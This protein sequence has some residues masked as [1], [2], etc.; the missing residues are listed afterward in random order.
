MFTY[1]KRQGLTPTD[2]RGL[3]APAIESLAEIQTSSSP[4]EEA[5]RQ[6]VTDMFARARAD[7]PQDTSGAAKPFRNPSALLPRSVLRVEISGLRGVVEAKS[8]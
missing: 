2:W 1:L 5:L 4:E 7:G 6:M 3:E 8:P